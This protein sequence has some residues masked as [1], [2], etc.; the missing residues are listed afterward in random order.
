L[1]RSWRLTAAGPLLA[2]DRKL[3][4]HDA[5]LAGPLPIARRALTRNGCRLR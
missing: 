2:K 3:D 1:G 4:M 5:G